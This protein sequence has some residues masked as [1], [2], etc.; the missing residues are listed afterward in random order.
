MLVAL[1]PSAGYVREWN[2]RA[3]SGFTA[4]GLRRAREG[5]RLESEMCGVIFEVAA[6]SLSR[7]DAREAG[8]GRVRLAARHFR[9]LD[10]GDAAEECLA[11]S[12]DTNAADA[13]HREQRHCLWTYVPLAPAPPD[14]EHPICQTYVDVC[15]L[16]CL[17]RGGAALAAEWVATTAGWSPFWLNDA[18]MSRRPWLHRHPSLRS[19]HWPCLHW[20]LHCS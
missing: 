17:E 10:D 19:H 1:A 5:E 16:G 6:E 14:E 11:A 9:R 15:L 18:P 12:G 3:P 20:C 4:T 7:F 2:F 13:N 8:Y